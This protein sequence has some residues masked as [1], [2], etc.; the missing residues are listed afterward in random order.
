M[1][2]SL[3]KKLVRTCF[4]QTQRERGK[5]RKTEG[6]KNKEE[7]KKKLVKTK[8]MEL[9]LLGLVCNGKL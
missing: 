5:E 3:T 9:T 7:D 6:E 1:N 4:I 8:Q 2:R